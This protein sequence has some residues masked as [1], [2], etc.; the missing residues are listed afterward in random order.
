MK[1]LIKK[2]IL[3]DMVKSRRWGG[4]HTELRNLSKGIPI[5]LIN[6]R[7][8]KKAFDKAVK[9][10]I[11]SGWLFA[12]K[13]TGEIHISLNPHYSKEILEFTA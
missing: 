6:T 2:E 3:R 5:Y 4:K 8:G 9:E 7:Q 11:N 12:K 10:L 13:S 1:E